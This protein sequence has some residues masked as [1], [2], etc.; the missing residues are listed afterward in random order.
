MATKSERNVKIS[1]RVVL[2][3]RLISFIYYILRQRKKM[4]KWLYIHSTKCPI[5]SH[6]Q[7][8]KEQINLLWFRKIFAETEW[9]YFPWQILRKGD[10]INLKRDMRTV[11]K[12]V[13]NLVKKFECKYFVNV[14]MR[15]V[16]WKD[17]LPTLLQFHIE[18]KKSAHIRALCKLE[19]SVRYT[20]NWGWTERNNR[21]KTRKSY[22][23]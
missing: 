3:A 4:P 19:Q 6:I 2:W 21:R 1:N 11:S 10:F 20:N 16:K 22:K 12:S 14:L 23:R 9:K 5:Y 13:R 18:L 7:I 8:H 15:W 17:W